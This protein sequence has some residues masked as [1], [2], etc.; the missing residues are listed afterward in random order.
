[1][2]HSSHRLGAAVVITAALF[3]L[4]AL[5]QAL[6]IPAK[7]ELAQWLIQRNWQAVRNGESAAPPW[8]WADTRAAARLQVPALSEELI[9]LAGNSGRNLAFGPVFDNASAGME[10]LVIHG[11]RDTHFA[12]LQEL[13]V[14]DELELERPDSTRR[15][16]VEASEVVDSRRR[17]LVLEPGLSRL[18]LVTCYPFDSPFSGGELRYVVT[19]VADISPRSASSG[20]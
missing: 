20:G 4:L 16:V 18:S 14:G 3:S 6:W 19:A 9:V 7:A 10:D 12:F 17:E 1:M 13:K 8:P 15:Y 5:A 11:H 2:R